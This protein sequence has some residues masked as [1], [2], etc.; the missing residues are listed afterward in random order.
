MSTLGSPLP[1]KGACMACMCNILSSLPRLSKIL[2]HLNNV[3]PP[4]PPFVH[5]SPFFL[6]M[7]KTMH[8][9]LVRSGCFNTIAC[10][11]H[12]TRVPIPIARKGVQVGAAVLVGN[13]RPVPRDSPPGHP[14]V[15]CEGA[16][17]HVRTGVALLSCGSHVVV[18]RVPCH[19]TNAERNR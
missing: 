8:K 17:D 12:T 14:R 1:L 6:A 11:V 9:P 7:H 10:A 2:S 19:L 18:V 13:V 15:D 4:T 3:C 5:V 16:M